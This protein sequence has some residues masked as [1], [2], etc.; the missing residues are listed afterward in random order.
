[1]KLKYG[2]TLIRCHRESNMIAVCLANFMILVIDLDT[3]AIIRKFV[4]HLA[5][6][7]DL[8]FSPDSRYIISASMD[9]TIKVWDIPSSYM[10][11]HFRVEQPCTSLTMSPNGNFLATAHAN[12]LGIYLWAN[13]MLFS[14]ISLRQID[15][16][17]EA[18][19]VCLPS[20]NLNKVSD[21]ESAENIDMEI[22][23]NEA[24]GDEIN[25]RYKTPEQLSNDLVTMSGE[26][27]SRWQNLL[28]L[29]IIKKRNKPKEPPKVPKQAPFFL[30]TVAGLEFKFDVEP[31]P[32]ESDNNSRIIK[33]NNFCNLTKFGKLLS[34]AQIS[35]D[36]DNC[37]QQLKTFGPSMID[38]EVKSLHPL[39]GGSNKVMVQFLHVLKFM[40]ESNKY[41]ELAQ[42]YLSVFLRVHGLELAETPDVIEALKEL[43][44]IQETSWQKLEEKIFF[45]LGALT[46]LRNFVD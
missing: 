44:A 25:F 38:F 18:P 36:Y 32:L 45:C 43:S 2:I 23:E 39:N 3:K 37:V 33:A 42:S 34:A 27:I 1:M 13:K 21:E 4:G 31:K 8:T 29:E 22:D 17:S 11:D 24:V 35:A 16:F 28:D 9:A 41:F 30:P 5:K 6:L 46:C 20:N 15:P 26:A 10:I 12:C 40:Y 14:Q 19:L 7:N